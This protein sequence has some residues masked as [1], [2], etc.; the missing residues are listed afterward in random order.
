MVMPTEVG[1]AGED[2]EEA[3]PLSCSIYSFPQW[4][5]ISRPLIYHMFR[6]LKAEV[7]M[8]NT[9]TTLQSYLAASVVQVG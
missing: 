8:R 1:Q 7:P 9:V 4:L 6:N 5:S 3:I 2:G